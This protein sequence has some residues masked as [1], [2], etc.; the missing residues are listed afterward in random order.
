M[1]NSDIKMALAGHTDAGVDGYC[2]IVSYLG[3][4]GYCLELA[5]RA[6]VST[7]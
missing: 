2:L 7:T 3:V 1:E 4:A 6:G 5:L